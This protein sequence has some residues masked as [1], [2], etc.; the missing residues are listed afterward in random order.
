MLRPSQTRE[1]ES[2]EDVALLALDFGRLLMEAGASARHV[3][4][5]TARVAVGLGA[6]RVELSVGYASLV[7]TVGT[8]V[9]TVVNGSYGVTRMCKVGPLGVNESLF[10]A[11]N[12]L[13]GRI[14]QG[15]LS[16]A[17]ARTELTNLLQNS[18]RHSDWV[19]AVAVGV[20]CA[21]F[22]RLLGVDWAGVGPI[23]VAATVAQRVRRQLALYH[24]NVFISA[25][26]VAF[27]G[28]GLC[29]LGAR[30]LGSQTLPKD[31][32]APVLLLVPG[33]PAFNAQY[34]T[35]E[36]HP[37]LG[38]ARAV[39]VMVMLVFMALGVWLAQGLLGG[40]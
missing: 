5:T 8:G 10:R 32:I 18:V 9:I 38:S 22:G 15:D 37:A 26:V 7:I 27:L 11:V 17:E 24:V 36:G 35:L 3:D 13:A 34:D 33:V 25:M 20:A 19:V 39:W 40:R 12:A 4:E 28:S 6:E 21:A 23:F 1:T 2:L 16:T 31:M 14:G 29:A 30:W